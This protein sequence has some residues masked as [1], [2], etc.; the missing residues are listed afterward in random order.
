[1]TWDT[2]HGPSTLYSIIQGGAGFAAWFTNVAKQTHAGLQPNAASTPIYVS[3]WNDGWPFMHDCCRNDPTY[4]PVMNGL[5]I[6]DYLNTVYSGSGA[7]PGKLF[8]YS[9]SAFPHFCMIGVWDSL[10]TCQY[11]SGSTPVPYPSYQPYN[12]TSSLNYLGLQNGGTMA[13][14]VTPGATQQGLAATAFYT[15]SKDAVLIVNPTPTNYHGVNFAFDNA[16]ISNAQG[17]YF[18]IDG[19]NNTIVTVPVTLGTTSSGYNASVDIPPY[20]VIA[21]AIQ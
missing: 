16:G 7:V 12:L 6:L 4:S 2:P 9:A 15:A 21:V 10:M 20:S 11:P 17:T 1:M 14:S 3:E 13:I 18:R 5:M 19:P 8:Y